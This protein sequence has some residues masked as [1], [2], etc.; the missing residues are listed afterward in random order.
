MS[1][2]PIAAAAGRGRRRRLG[3]W[4]ALGALAVTIGLLIGAGC[5]LTC[6][7]NWYRPPAIDYSRLDADKR[8]ATNLGDRIGDG[9]N[10][11]RVVELELDEAQLNRWIA[12]RNELPGGV[13]LDLGPLR[14]PFVDLLED[15]RIRLA[16]LVER[17][18]VALVASVSF[19][20]ALEDDAIRVRIEDVRAGAAPAPME[21]IEPL[22]REAFARSGQSDRLAP[23]GSIVVPND[24]VW[25]NGKKRF[26]IASIEIDD[27]LARVRLEPK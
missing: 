26:R 13:P 7:P 9:L 16:A 24:L 11:R 20:V 17:G 3:R 10:S 6:R 4:I 2:P 23:D 25:P 21:L 1:N 12:A 19:K 27:N 8:D 15:N 14:S 22:L 18:G 5:A